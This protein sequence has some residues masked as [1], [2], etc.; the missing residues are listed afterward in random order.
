MLA[1]PF[2]DQDIIFALL[3]PKL[4]FDG[5]VREVFLRKGSVQ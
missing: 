2:T 3:F 1:D 5:A 4:E